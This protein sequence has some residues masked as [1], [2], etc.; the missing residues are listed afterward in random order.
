VIRDEDEF[1]PR[2]R[3]QDPPPGPDRRPRP[4]Q[5]SFAGQRA[6]P[7]RRALTGEQPAFAPSARSEPLRPPERP[8]DVNTGTPAPGDLEGA[9]PGDNSGPRPAGPAYTYGPDDPGYGPPGSD[10]HP[11]EEAARRQAAEEEL[12]GARGA[13]EPLPADHVIPGPPP[14]MDDDEADDDVDIDLAGGGDGP[15][16]DRIRDLYMTAE[17]VGESRLDKHFEQLLE[18]QRQLIREYFADTDSRTQAG[19]ARG[20]GRPGRRE[21]ADMSPGGALRSRR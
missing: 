20:S 17:S 18:R 8:A 5:Q 13:F 14:P 4:D 1:A 6:R 21:S 10:W 7:Q 11:R 16:L 3:R 9:A 12:R 19:P 15:P 2:Q